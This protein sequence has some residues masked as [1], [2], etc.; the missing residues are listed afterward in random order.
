MIYYKVD[1][2]ITYIKIRLDHMFY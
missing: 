2:Y 1:D